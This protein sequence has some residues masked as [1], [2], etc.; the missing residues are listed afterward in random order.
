MRRDRYHDIPPASSIDIKE[1]IEERYGIQDGGH[2]LQRVDGMLSS[3]IEQL[4]LNDRIEKETQLLRD[5][6]SSQHTI[7]RKEK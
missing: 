2:V 6:Y 7:R 4:M 5:L 1:A 3:S